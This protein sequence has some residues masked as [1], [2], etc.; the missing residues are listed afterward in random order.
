MKRLFVVYD[1][2]CGLC[3]Q[4]KGWLTRQ[5]AYVPLSFVASS[6]AEARQLIPQLPPGELAIV[7]DEGEIWIGNRAW[8]LCLWALREYRTWASRLSSPALLPFAQQAFAVL[9]RNR[10][11]L[12]RILRLP[13]DLKI[14]EALSRVRLPAC[15]INPLNGMD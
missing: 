11:G 12:S 3:S 5:P 14:G 2:T 6:S 13:S 7:S 10:A 8:V 4:I 9:S 1:P 15:P